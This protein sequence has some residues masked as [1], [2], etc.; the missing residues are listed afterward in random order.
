MLFRSGSDDR[1]EGNEDVRLSLLSGPGYAV[2]STAEALT[3]LVDN[4]SASGAMAGVAIPPRLASNTA[5]EMRNTSAFAALK[6]D[7]SVYPFRGRDT[8]T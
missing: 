2:A 3:I 6:G 5:F 8:R 1:F 7:G 4:D